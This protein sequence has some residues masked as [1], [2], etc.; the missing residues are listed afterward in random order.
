MPGFKELF[1][2]DM[3]RYANSGPDPYVKRLIRLFRKA[4]TRKS[5]AARYFYRVL[6]RLHC[7]KRGIEIPWNTSIGRGIYLGHVYNITV[8]PGAVIGENCNIH[9]GVLIGQSNRGPSKGVPTLGNCVWVGIN[10]A[11]VGGVTIGEDV[12]IA[13]NS[14]VNRDV[15]SHSVVFGNPCIIKSRENAVE[16]YINHKA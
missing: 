4:Q 3:A 7:S 10:A 16:G 15:P 5:S 13:P 6:Y 9:K 14:F 8:N 1:K 12:L 2:A 11:I